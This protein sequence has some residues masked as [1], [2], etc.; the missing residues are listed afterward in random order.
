[1]IYSERKDA[2]KQNNGKSSLFTSRSHHCFV[3]ALDKLPSRELCLW[4]RLFPGSLCDSPCWARPAISARK[5]AVRTK[6]VSSL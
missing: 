3:S 4:E 5:E 6:P 2:D 1:M